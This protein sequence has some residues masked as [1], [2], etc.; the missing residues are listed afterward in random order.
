MRST[1]C[2][3]F[4]ALVLSVGFLV[5]CTSGSGSA[6]AQSATP[7]ALETDEQKTLYA[8]GQILG[9]NI[10]DAG[11]SEED[12]SPVLLGLSDAALGRE[13]QVDLDAYGPM[14]QGFMQ[15]RIAAAAEAELAESTA[16]L[17]AQAAQDGAVRTDSGIVIQEITPGSGAQPTA[18]DTVRVHYHGTL[19]D[20]SVFDSS[21]ERGEPATFPLGQVIP[22]WTEAV[23][24]MRVG[25]KSRLVCPPDLAYG[26]N[27]APGIAPNSAL[28]FEVELLDIVDPQGP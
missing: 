5:A 26:S 10:A 3:F 17:D 12:L 25:G 6:E 28:V 9:G 13:A 8:L 14:V 15:V 19:R 2:C 4:A 21:V 20:G 16:F 11:L 7:A 1:V 27:G 24:T 18:E 22:C 23:Q